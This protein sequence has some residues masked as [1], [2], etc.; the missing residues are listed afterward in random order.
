MIFLAS[1]Y[2]HPDP[3]VRQVRYDAAVSAMAILVHEGHDCFSPIAMTHEA[4][5]ILQ[6]VYEDPDADGWTRWWRQ[7]SELLRISNL[8]VVLGID[9]WD[10]SQGVAHEIGFAHQ[11]CIPVVLLDPE[12]LKMSLM[13]PIIPEPAAPLPGT[14]PAS[15]GS[16]QRG[17]PPARP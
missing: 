13:S 8:V 6:D 12:T 1:P 17:R 7:N 2:S 5:K 15:S 16:K 4:A 9:G 3:A 10:R 11:C 14:P